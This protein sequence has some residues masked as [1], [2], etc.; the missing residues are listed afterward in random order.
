MF[1][2]R[3]VCEPRMFASRNVCEQR[4]FASRNVCEQRMF[5][6]RNVCEQRMFASG[7]VC[8]PG[9]FSKKDEQEGIFMLKKK[10]SKPFKI[11]VDHQENTMKGEKKIAIFAVIA[12]FA[13]VLALIIIEESLKCRFTVENNT[14]KNIEHIELSFIDEENYLVETVYDGEVKAGDS[15]KGKFE[16]VDFSL[17]SGELYIGVTFEGGE[18]ITLS[19]GFLYT[20][21]DG[22][23]SLE[24]V[25]EDGEYRL[26]TDS[27]VGLFGSSD[28]AGIENKFFIDLENSDWFEMIYDDEQEKWVIDEGEYIDWEDINIEGDEDFDD[29]VYSDEELIY[30]DE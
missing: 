25:Q 17:Y 10:S 5:A 23:F 18:E 4:M 3:N 28:I 9:K 1:A 21:F 11:R 14:D 19:D 26:N 15:V 13:I 29:E 12:L 8:E 16:P 7:N 22:R 2:N 30:P 24:F 20:L 27:A 6:S